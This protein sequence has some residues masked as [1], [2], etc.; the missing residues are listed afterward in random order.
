L[1]GTE[2]TYYVGDL[3]EKMEAST[4]G[5]TYWRHYVPT[6]SGKTIVVSRNSDLSTTTSLVL[7]DHL[8]SSDAI[9]NALT[10]SINVQESFSPFGLR[11]QSNWAAGVPSYWDQVAITQSTRRGFTFHEHFDNVGLI[12]INGRVYDPA[13]GRSLSADLDIAD[14]A[15]TQSVNPYSYVGNRPLIA[16]DPSG[17]DALFEDSS[18]CQFSC[19]GSNDVTPGSQGLDTSESADSPDTAGSPGSA[20]QIIGNANASGATDQFLAGATPLSGGPGQPADAPGQVAGG[21]TQQPSAGPTQS[22]APSTP[23]TVVVQGKRFGPMVVKDGWEYP[24]CEKR[25]LTVE[26]VTITS[27]RARPHSGPVQEAPLVET[28]DLSI[29]LPEVKGA[30]ILGPILKKALVGT[31]EKEVAGQVAKQA[32]KSATEVGKPFT[33]A[34]KRDIL[35]AN[36]ARNGG[37]LRSDKSGQELVPGKQSQRGVTPPENEAHVDH[38]YPRS[39][40]GSNDP[41]NAQA[42]SRKE[43]LDK[44]DSLP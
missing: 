25:E 24:C 14:F 39:Q 22:E 8:G 16:T 29:F 4:T 15:D 40:G 36:R 34:T 28:L 11:R 13:I 20:Q 17:F 32:A 27:P 26:Q 31:A 44:S 18:Q 23:D 9:V 5:I 38:I 12:H 30:I 21:S 37:V 6:P 10:G 7:S 43:N 42:L 33:R 35:D 19:Q 2:T 3:L 1:N 41:S